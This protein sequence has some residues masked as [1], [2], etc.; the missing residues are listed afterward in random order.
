MSYVYIVH[1]LHKE[2][3]EH[4]ELKSNTKQQIQKSKA[5]K[6]SLN[7]SYHQVANYHFGFPP[8]LERLNSSTLLPTGK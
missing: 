3:K 2:R 1:N 8:S 4:K 7:V 5:K 6:E